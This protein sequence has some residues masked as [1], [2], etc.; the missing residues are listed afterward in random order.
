MIRKHVRSLLGQLYWKASDVAFRILH[1]PLTKMNFQETIDY[2][3]EY[4]CSISRYGDGEIS[5]MLG[6]SL[7]FQPY[8][9]ALGA[10][11]R[12][13][14]RNPKILVCIP[15]MFGDMEHLTAESREFWRAYYRS[16]RAEFHHIFPSSRIYGDACITRFYIRT[17]DKQK[18]GE[19]IDS[20][21]RLWD[22]RDIVFIEG[23]YSRL[24]VGN[25]LFANAA[26]KKR[27]LV[28]SVNAFS[29]YDR[30]LEIVKEFPPNTLFIMAAGPTATALAMDID[31]LGYQAFDL[32]HI[33]LEYEWWKMGV[34]K[35]VPIPGKYC[36]ETYLTNLS[37]AEV[38]GSL[39]SDDWQLYQ[40]EIVCDLVHHHTDDR[41]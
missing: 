30:I 41:E 35:R 9:P 10:K 34:T 23:E 21:K 38:S 31:A 32:G 7:H 37:D 28:P 5:L 6:K 4:R 1:R 39:K 17:R 19:M 8:V 14:L 12:A 20:L 22:G 36:N 25:D 13:V 26:S 16:H 11:L 27:I 3:L 33:D 15:D 24:G 2:I 29:V 18:V 40:N